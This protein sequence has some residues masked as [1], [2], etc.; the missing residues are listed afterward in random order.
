M[1]LHDNKKPRD[2][3]VPH[4]SPNLNL[5]PLCATTGLPAVVL[6]SSVDMEHF[7]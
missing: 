2:V 4:H 5:P 7:R 3:R 6:L 1:I